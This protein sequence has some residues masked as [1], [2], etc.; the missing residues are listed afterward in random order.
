MKK[1]PF[2]AYEYTIPTGR[3]LIDMNLPN[4]K[5]PCKNCPFRKDCLEGW[6]GK[7]RMSEILQS[8]SFPCHKNKKLQCAGH[9]ILKGE[10]NEFVQMAKIM[11]ISTSLKGHK[12]IFEKEEDL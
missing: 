3:R 2:Q 11:K 8:S 5:T 9:M 7:N 12:L 1:T 6:L 10:E 4:R